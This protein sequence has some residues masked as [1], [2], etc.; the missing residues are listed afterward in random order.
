MKMLF[1]HDHKF[2]RINKDIYSPGGLSN[3]ILSR[4]T[5]M[6]GE[7]VVSARIIEESSAKKNY[8]KIEN[9][10]IKITESND[11]YTLVQEADCLVI[12]LPSVKGYVAE[13][14]ASKMG[15][16]FLV[17]VVGCVWDS[18]WNYGIKGKIAAPFA[19]LLMKHEVKKSK[20]TLYVTQDFLQKRYPCKGLTT[21]V[22]DVELPSID[23]SVLNN[24]K[25]RINQAKKKIIIGTI[26]AIDVPYKGHEYVI[27]ALNSIHEKLHVEVEYQMV[28][29]GE[30]DRLKRIASECNVEKKVKFVGS[31]PHEKIFD[32]LDSIDY[33][34]QPSLQEGL[35]RSLVEA[36]SRGLPCLASDVG[37][38]YECI[39]QDYIFKTANKKM[40]PSQISE[41][42]WR[43]E[44]NDKSL[45]EA[46]KNFFRAKD[47]FDKV[48]LER[49]RLDFYDSFIKEF[50]N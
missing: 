47:F 1:V 26:A 18:Y 13:E 20:Y 16:P 32:W 48:V 31:L 15:K 24:R 7:V 6:F 2:R 42:L 44:S 5:V 8:S 14:I 38:N 37:G 17:E 23:E 36:M 10:N 19:Y 3:E 41:L 33:Y 21:G 9:P 27:K 35:C 50:T 12:R 46:E 43:L 28:G 49:R 4:Y 11:L 34:I 45:I 29:G 30:T 22:S 39:T 40:I 25:K